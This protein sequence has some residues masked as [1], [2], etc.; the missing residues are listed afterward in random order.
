MA[1][2]VRSDPAADRGHLLRVHVGATWALVGLIWFVQVVH[3]P[4]FASVGPGEFAHY[5]AQYTR[6]TARVVGVIMP[7]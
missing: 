6:R 4:L 1:A 2:S 7:A 5:E 3:Y